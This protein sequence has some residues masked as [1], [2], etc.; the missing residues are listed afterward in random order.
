M[1]SDA[2]P[3]VM[4]RRLTAELRRLRALKE[5]TQEEV[6]N[7]LEWSVSRVTR[8]SG[9]VP[10]Y[11]QASTRFLIKLVITLISVLILAALS[12]ISRISSFALRIISACLKY[13]HRQEPASC[14]SPPVG[15]INQGMLAAVA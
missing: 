3:V 11:A 4:R 8:T 7:A 13:G 5:H 1:N 15:Q 14:C 9:W 12:Q 2:S 10:L 6:A